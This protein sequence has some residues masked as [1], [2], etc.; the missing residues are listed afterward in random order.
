MPE[1]TFAQPS[2]HETALWQ[3]RLRRSVRLYLALDDPSMNPNAVEARLRLVERQL[4][5]HLLHG[6]PP[7]L[8]ATAKAQHYVQRAQEA[9]LANEADVRAILAEWSAEQAVDPLR[10]AV[11]QAG[12][13]LPDVA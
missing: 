9:L 11:Q 3:F 4:M 6:Q 8:M 7:T 1:S 5:R 10:W 12:G 13:W 2:A